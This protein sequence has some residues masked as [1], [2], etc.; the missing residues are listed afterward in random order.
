MEFGEF[1][2][3][4]LQSSQSWYNS[5]FVCHQRAQNNAV[6]QQI[7]NVDVSSIAY[8]PTLEHV[9]VANALEIAKNNVD[10]AMAC[11]EQHLPVIFLT[12][13]QRYEKIK[14]C[15]YSIL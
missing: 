4:Q 13:F 3:P 7:S 9:L 8:A 11:L 1:Q 2:S 14:F 10:Q 15:V 5:P 12:K 6:Q